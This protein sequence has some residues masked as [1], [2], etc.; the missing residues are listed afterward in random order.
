MVLAAWQKTAHAAR[1]QRRVAQAM[2]RG[3]F[4]A[5]EAEMSSSSDEGQRGARP[6]SKKLRAAQ[7]RKVQVHVLDDSD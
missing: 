5:S 2:W 4:S 7:A 6:A 1:W 3:A